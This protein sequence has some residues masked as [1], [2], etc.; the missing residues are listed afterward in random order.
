VSEGTLITG[1]IQFSGDLRIDGRVS[2]NVRS[3][4]GH[5]GTLIV[6]EKAHVD[7]DVE[8]ARLVAHG[9]ITGRVNVSKF[10]RIHAKARIN[11]DLAYTAV[12]VHAGAVVQ[13]RLLH[14]QEAG[15]IEKSPEPIAV[16]PARQ[17]QVPDSS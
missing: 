8:V 4:E 9:Q 5:S 1:T 7:G 14:R 3:I 11:C 17:N 13:G 10:V 15:Q 16:Q 2:G 6:G 12:E